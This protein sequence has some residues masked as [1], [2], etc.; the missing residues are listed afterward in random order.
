VP[1]T[2]RPD[3]PVLPAVKRG[4]R[5]GPLTALG[6]PGN[7]HAIGAF[8]PAEAEVTGLTTV[9]TEY[10]CDLPAVRLRLS[11]QAVWPPPMPAPALY[12]MSIKPAIPGAGATGEP[13]DP[14]HVRGVLAEM[15]PLEDLPATLDELGVLTTHADGPEPLGRLLRHASGRTNLLVINAIQSEPRL[16]SHRRLTIEGLGA[17]VTGVRA[18]MT[19]LGLRRATLLVGASHGLPLGTLRWLRRFGIRTLPVRTSF[20]GSDNSIVLRRLFHRPATDGGD[21]TSSGCL[22]LPADSVWR[23]GL[24]LLHRRP[25]PFQLVTVAGDCLPPASQRVY[26]LPIGLTIHGLIQCLRE[27]NLL[28][29]EPKV[30]LLGGPLTG[31]AIGDPSRTVVT[32]T[33]Q[34]VLL[35]SRKP[36]LRTT[37]C[38]RCGWCIDGCPVGIDPIAILDA[39]EAD[40]PQALPRPAAL[41]CIGG[42]VC[43]AVCPSHLPLAQAARTARMRL[44]HRTD[45]RSP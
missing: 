23:A 34:A 25:V 43:S 32:Q 28:P 19:C 12:E 45:T 15:A 7:S 6:Q 16:A 31:T 8:S 24:A 21:G 35:M 37:G 20:P 42:G 10:A 22:V 38:I 39:L 9:D 4:G 36:R 11:A 14:Q 44:A 30:V 17:V 2:S 1:L 33:T 13:A 18:M 3:M 41:R 29:R 40:P 26:L 27:R 5:V